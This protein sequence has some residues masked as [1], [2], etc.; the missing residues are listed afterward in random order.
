MNCEKQGQH[1][2]FSVVTVSSSPVNQHMDEPVMVNGQSS[3]TTDTGKPQSKESSPSKSNSSKDASSPKE[4]LSSLSDPEAQP[5]IQ[6]EK[7]QRNSSGKSKVLQF[8]IYT[9]MSI[10]ETIAPLN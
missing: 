3:D 1:L 4:R 2:L 9:I 6:V 10:S 7:R 5:W 8:R